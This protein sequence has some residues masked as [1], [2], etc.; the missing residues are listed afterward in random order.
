MGN[1]PIGIFL[2]MTSGSHQ[3]LSAMSWL[4]RLSSLCPSAPSLKRRSDRLICLK[5]TPR[6]C[7]SQPT[8]AIHYRRRAPSLF[9][10]PRPPQSRRR[11]CPMP[12][13]PKH[14][15]SP[16]SRRTR[17]V[18]L[19]PKH[20]ANRRR[21]LLRQRPPESQKFLPTET[22][23]QSRAIPTK[24]IPSQQ[25]QPQQRSP[26]DQPGSSSDCPADLSSAD[27]A[28]VYKPINDVDADVFRT[29]SQA[30]SF[31]KPYLFN[32]DLLDKRAQPKWQV[33]RPQP[34]GQCMVWD[35]RP[36]IHWYGGSLPDQVAQT[37]EWWY[38]M[39]HSDGSCCLSR[40][41]IFLI[42]DL[43]NE[44]CKPTPKQPNALP[45]RWLKLLVFMRGLCQRE[46]RPTHLFSARAR[47]APVRSAVRATSLAHPPDRLPTA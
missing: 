15:R 8:K 12:P 18:H 44:V 36:W 28:M 24:P 26:S 23:P 7:I 10:A 4:M 13:S 6:P 3:P 43:I 47:P 14:L 40:W 16:S 41:P 9:K 29:L 21:S 30:G 22:E 31:T 20:P 46:P 42:K 5:Q 33:G 37:D 35:H 39:Y 32:Q 38:T 11:P 27:P 25:Q 17:H 19:S 2:V 34:V 45:G 1:G